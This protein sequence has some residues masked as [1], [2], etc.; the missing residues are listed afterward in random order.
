MDDRVIDWLADA[1][2][3]RMFHGRDQ[4]YFAELVDLELRER[5]EHDKKVREKP[6]DDKFEALSDGLAWLVK[7][8]PAHVWRH[9]IE[10][11]N[12]LK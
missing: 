10:N 4:R 9:E 5:E 11:M 3:Q 8:D 6:I 12:P 2:C 7:K 1:D